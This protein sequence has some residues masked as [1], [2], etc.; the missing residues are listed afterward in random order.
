MPLVTVKDKFQ[1]TIPAKLR[2]R[3]PLRVG[4]LLEATV[5]G[6]GILLRPKAVVDRATVADELAAL[7]R[8]APT[9]PEDAGKPES[10]ILEEASAD[11]AAARARRRRKG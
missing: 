3:L 5:H 10:V 8:A 1:V 2:E 4:E 6:D 9:A 7:L 11:V